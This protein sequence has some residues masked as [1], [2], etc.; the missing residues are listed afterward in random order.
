[1]FLPIGD[2]GQELFCKACH[3]FVISRTKVK[4][5]IVLM[6]RW[7]TVQGFQWTLFC[8]EM[9]GDMALWALIQSPTNIVV[10]IQLQTDT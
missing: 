4:I 3:A 6:L 1:M 9:C 7:G 8:I 5:G 2:F 10:L